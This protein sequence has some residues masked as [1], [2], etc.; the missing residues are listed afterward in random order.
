MIERV[1]MASAEA[2]GLALDRSIA[3][4][5]SHVMSGDTGGTQT[6]LKIAE[7]IYQ[8]SLNYSRLEFDC[9]MPPNVAINHQFCIC[10]TRAR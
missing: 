4:M 10:G 3:K 8:G 7:G 9:S 6:I 2:Y 1:S 5:C